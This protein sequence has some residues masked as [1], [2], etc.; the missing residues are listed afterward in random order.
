MVLC[1]G[2]PFEV[3]KTFR[4]CKLYWCFQNLCQIRFDIYIYIYIYIY[5]V[6]DIPCF[7]AMNHVRVVLLNCTCYLI[8]LPKFSLQQSLWN[9]PQVNA[10]RP[11]RWLHVAINGFLMGWCRWA[12]GHYLNQCWPWSQMPYG[13]IRPQW[14][15][16][17][18]DLRTR[19]CLFVILSKYLLNLY[20]V[21]SDIPV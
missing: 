13:V 7:L 14:V 11:H 5:V 2:S 6:T 20:S 16:T 4:Y 19:L 8:A 17:F 1:R 12:T 10:T 15:K 9:W 21:Y 18:L 3:H